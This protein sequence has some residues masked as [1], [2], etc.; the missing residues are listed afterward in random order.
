MGPQIRTITQIT[1]TA[2]LKIKAEIIG[3]QSYQKV[4]EMS[5]DRVYEL[6]KLK[7]QIELEQRRDICQIKADLM[8]DQIQEDQKEHVKKRL[9][10]MGDFMGPMLVDYIWWK[11]AGKV[12][13]EEVD[14]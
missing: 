14:E 4:E 2:M 5:I 10:E 6:L 9:E 3:E 12:E 8:G 7:L 11:T 13:W 1:R